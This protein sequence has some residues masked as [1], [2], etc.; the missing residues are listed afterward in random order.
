MLTLHPKLHA[1]VTAARKSGITKHLVM[2][3]NG[4]LLNRMSDDV[5]RELDE[6]E[7]SRY[8][9]SGLSDESISAAKE[10]G[11]KYDTKVTL[12]VFSDFRHTF[13]GRAIMDADLTKKVFAACKI[14]NVWGCHAL[15][16]GHIYRCPQSIYAPKIAGKDF[17]D[18]FKLDGGPALQQRLL[19]FLNGNVPLRSCRHC[20]GT[21]GRKIPHELL[22]RSKWS[23][24][25]NTPP[26]EM[27]DYELLE[28]SL[29]ES[30]NI[31]DCRVQLKPNRYSVEYFRNKIQSFKRGTG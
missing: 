24:D 21:S 12:T 5:W 1:V 31:D 30:S 14:A 25:M 27:I 29:V 16:R 20:V 15:Y 6:V 18:G 13:S 8:P 11:W 23:D 26:E 17:N 10:K 2:I 3:T 28:R 7:I 4:L 22:H 9:N 19:E